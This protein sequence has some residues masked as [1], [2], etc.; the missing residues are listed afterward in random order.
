MN[1]KPRKCLKQKTL[2]NDI[3]II[4]KMKGEI[5]TFEKKT[6][7]NDITED[8]NI[9]IKNKGTGAGGKNTNANGLNFEK[10]TNFKNFLDKL[11]YVD[12]S[13]S[14]FKSF[15]KD[16]KINKS[17]IDGC[18]S[19]DEC[20]INEETKHVIVIE[21]KFQNVGGSV[22]E[23]IQTAPFKKLFFEKLLP[24]YK[25]TYAY[26]LSKWFE[27]NCA[28]VIEILKENFNIP[29]LCVKDK[30]IDEKFIDELMK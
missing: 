9:S 7:D 29:I 4:E 27:N 10:E 12:Y 22:C 30:Y 2:S 28:E 15:L 1:V 13:K 20:Y 5:D 23:K 6:I 8:E 21:K 18:K 26:V 14:S 16:K 3:D 11:G 25:I 19:P 17:L 24:T